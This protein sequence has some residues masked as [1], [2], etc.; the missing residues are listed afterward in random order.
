MSLIKKTGKSVV[1]SMR[2]CASTGCSLAFAGGWLFYLS[3]H[4]DR[5]REYN[6]RMLLGGTGPETVS[7]RWA[8]VRVRK[9]GWDD[10]CCMVHTWSKQCV[11]KS[12][13]LVARKARREKQHC[14]DQNRRLL[15]PSE[16]HRHLIP[17]GSL[18]ST[19]IQ[20]ERRWGIL[21]PD[22]GSSR[23]TRIWEPCL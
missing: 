7:W 21:Y 16:F 13:R 9:A 18:W 20:Q 3:F 4:V 15:R 14:S 11:A 2:W 8:R 6:E 22:S 17:G 5:W 10:R 12:Q 19:Q 1:A 23:S